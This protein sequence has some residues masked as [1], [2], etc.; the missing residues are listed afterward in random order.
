MQIM[1]TSIPANLFSYYSEKIGKKIDINFNDKSTR[2][3][4]KKVTINNEKCSIELIYDDN[5]V[6]N[7]IFKKLNKGKQ[8]ISVGYNMEGK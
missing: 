1:K 4:I 3:L 8:N 2:A 5:E 6:T 7:E